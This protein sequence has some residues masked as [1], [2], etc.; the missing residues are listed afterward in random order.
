MKT[1]LGLEDFFG[2]CCP[3]T[4]TQSIANTIIVSKFFGLML[5]FIAGTWVMADSLGALRYD[6]M[7]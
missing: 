1:M 2:V 6:F 7:I 5:P 4:F 3:C